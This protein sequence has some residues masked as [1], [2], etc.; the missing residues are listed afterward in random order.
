MR[1]TARK[2]S[3][4]YLGA[5][6]GYRRGSAETRKLRRGSVKEPEGKEN[7]MEIFPSLKPK[8]IVFD[9]GDAS[10]LVSFEYGHIR[11]IT[12][13]KVCAGKSGQNLY[14]KSGARI[15][16]AT[17]SI[18]KQIKRAACMVWWTITWRI[19]RLIST[20]RVAFRKK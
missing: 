18:I 9:I 11:G 3:N 10:Y 2:Q 12:N 19:K 15:I 16:G 1:L 20:R 5:V 8:F 13:V 4:G 17:P 14:G 7:A 6:Q